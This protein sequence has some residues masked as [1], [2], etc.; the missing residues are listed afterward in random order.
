[1]SLIFGAATNA[2]T[3]NFTLSA[4]ATS[5]S[6]SHSA[7]L[8][9]TV[10]KGIISTLPRTGYAT[11]DAIAALDDPP[12]EPHHRHIAYD[13]AN[14]HLFIANRAM[15]RVEVLSSMDRSRVAEISVPGASSADISADG[16]T[17]WIGTTTEQII[18]I[19]SGTL[20]IQTRYSLPPLQPLPGVT[21]DR[22]EEVVALS[23]GKLLVRLRQASASEALLALWDPVHPPYSKAALA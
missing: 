17:I 9:L 16:K 8:S 13:S 7:S 10:Q 23:S 20:Q 12:G 22:P 14:K 4:Q 2:A 3:G 6:L 18:A 19:D 5:G 21:F 11:T 15:N 1:V